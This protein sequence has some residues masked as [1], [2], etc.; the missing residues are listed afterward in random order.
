MGYSVLRAEITS[1]LLN[2]KP[3]DPPLRY[4]SHIRNM[5]NECIFADEAEPRALYLNTYGKDSVNKTDKQTMTNRY[6]CVEYT[7][8]T[9][10]YVSYIM[11]T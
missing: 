10:E 5:Y 1:Y 3:S 2:L 8:N 9:Y 7:H 11:R 4:V 6:D